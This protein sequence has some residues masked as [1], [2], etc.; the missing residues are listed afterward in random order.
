MLQEVMSSVYLVHLDRDTPDHEVTARIGALWER[1]G[2]AGCFTRNDLAALKLHVGEPGRD[3]F[4]SPK[5]AAALVKLMAETGARPFLTDTAV[6]YKSRRDN[7]VGHAG[8]A[9]EHGFGPDAVGAPF[10]PADGLN[11][12]DEIEIE[13]GGEHYRHVSIAPAIVHARSMLVLSHATGHAGTG[14]GGALKNLGMGCCSKMGKLRQHHGHEP[15]IDPK[16][17]TACGTCAEHCPTGAIRVNSHAVIDEEP[18][19]GCG[20]CIAV[21]LDGAVLFDWA[22]GGRELQERIVEHAA[23]VVRGK[24]GRLA[25]VTV[26][27]N[28][29]KDCDCLNLVQPSVVEDIGILASTDPVAIDAVVMDL[30]RARSGQSIESLSYPGRNASVQIEHARGLGLGDSEVELIEF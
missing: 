25:C 3:T 8:V 14:Y 5:I 12:A 26:A 11:G 7:G 29:T 2:L 23:A 22:V 13:V 19:I 28:I 10:I 21:C 30:I 27:M 1:A 18:C 9:L 15:R 17:C 24:P 6:L 4:V 20:E 16:A